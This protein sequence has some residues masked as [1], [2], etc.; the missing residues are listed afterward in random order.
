[1]YR[2]AAD[3]N[4]SL[5]QLKQ[6]AQKNQM[7]YQSKRDITAALLKVEMNKQQLQNRN[8]NAGYDTF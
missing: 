5:E 1:M 2:Y 6:S 4:L 7:D 3:Q 8:M